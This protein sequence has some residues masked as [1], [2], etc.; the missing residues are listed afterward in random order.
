MVYWR[1]DPDHGSQTNKSSTRH[2][3]GQDISLQGTYLAFGVIWGNPPRH[4]G[5]PVA[6][7]RASPKDNLE[8]Y[9]YPPKGMKLTAEETASGGNKPVVKLMNIYN[10]TSRSFVASNDERKV[11]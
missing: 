10:E 9:M 4:G 7:T 1:I 6:Y 2:D 3:L 5:I 11:T 8:I